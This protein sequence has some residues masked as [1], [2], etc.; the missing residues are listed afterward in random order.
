LNHRARQLVAAVAIASCGCS[1]SP[2]RPQHS[3]APPTSGFAATTQQTTSVAAMLVSSR[4]PEGMRLK[5]LDFQRDYLE[6]EGAGK[7]GPKFARLMGTLRVLCDHTLKED[8]PVS[9]LEILELLGPPDYGISEQR[10]AAFTYICGD[11]AYDI[12]IGPDGLVK[13][14]GSRPLSD[15]NLRDTPRWLPY[16]PP[17]AVPSGTSYLGIEVAVDDDHAGVR[18]GLL[19]V[20]IV[21]G[22]PASKSILKSG[23]VILAIDGVPMR[24]NDAPLFRQKTA[25]MRPGDIAAIRFIT[26]EVDGA[27]STRD[28]KVAAATWTG[29]L[30]PQGE[31]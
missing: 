11:R 6:N 17:S 9:E 1:T 13:D 28:V 24:A 10:G 23:D 30:D 18:D 2:P 21:P 5:L 4:R 19:V 16:S 7:K 3:I 8:A 25:R 29:P 26:R 27:A 31:G 15:A 14:V 22:S 12:D 20:G